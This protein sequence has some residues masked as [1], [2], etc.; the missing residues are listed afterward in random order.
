MK[1]G[2]ENYVTN[3]TQNLDIN[4]I[5]VFTIR[6]LIFDYWMDKT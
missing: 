4:F 5:A 2:S 1:K 6:N 3:F